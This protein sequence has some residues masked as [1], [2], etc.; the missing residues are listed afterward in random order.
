[1]YIQANQSMY[2]MRS[3]IWQLSPEEFAISVKESKS[4]ADL[5]RL[6]YGNERNSKTIKERIKKDCID[7]SHFTSRSKFKGQK[8][9][10][11][12]HPRYE[13]DQLLKQNAHK[14]HGSRLKDKL[15]TNNILFN[16]CYVCGINEWQGKEISLQLIHVNRDS[17]D[18][19][20]DNLILLCPNCF[21]QTKGG[22]TETLQQC[23]CGIHLPPNITE[24][25]CLKKQIKL[26]SKEKL[27][28]ELI[29]FNFSGVQKKYGVDKDA[30]ISWINN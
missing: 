14:I 23:S 10:E 26:P 9:P 15:I 3:F 11:N 25:K 12:S 29:T 22:E 6:Y 13:L 17:F 16:Q 24:H 18:N 21:S 28:K 19:R 8:R 1:M 30:I 20:I 27:Q 2:K 4:Y 7:I 5:S